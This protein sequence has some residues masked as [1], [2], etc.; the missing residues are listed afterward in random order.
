V[1]IRGSAIT[2]D[3]G[4][5]QTDDEIAQARV[6]LDLH[7]RSRTEGLAL[8]LGA[9]ADLSAGSLFGSGRDYNVAL[10]PPPMWGAEVSVGFTYGARP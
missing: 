4:A 1:A 3:D 10:P 5:A 6:G 7:W 9:R 2:A 8:L